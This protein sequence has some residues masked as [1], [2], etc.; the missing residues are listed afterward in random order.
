MGQT[1]DVQ[2]I[3]DAAGLGGDWRERRFWNF[4]QEFR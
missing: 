4:A 3:F 2:Q 1:I